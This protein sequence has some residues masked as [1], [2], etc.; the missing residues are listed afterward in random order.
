MVNDLLNLAGNA[1]AFIPVAVAYLVLLGLT[2][3]AGTLV[4]YSAGAFGVGVLFFMI[5]GSLAG[6]FS[7]FAW[8]VLTPLD[9]GIGVM[10][11]CAGFAVCAVWLRRQF[12]GGGQRDQVER[13]RAATRTRE[14]T[15][16][17]GPDDGR[18]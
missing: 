11:V 15:R 16:L 8:A 10:F 18:H 5:R 6:L 7:M 1:L 12:G 17:L 2:R 14:R 9:A 3:E 4:R 13:E